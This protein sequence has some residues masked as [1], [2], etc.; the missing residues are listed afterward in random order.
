MYCSNGI[1]THYEH[2]F[3]TLNIYSIRPLYFNFLS[4]CDCPIT[5]SF[6]LVL[7]QREKGFV[8]ATT[9]RCGV[10]LDNL[11]GRMKVQETKFKEISE[12]KKVM[13]RANPGNL[14]H[15]NSSDPDLATKRPVK[16]RT[17]LYHLIGLQT[18]YL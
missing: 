10:G 17:N 12:S 18:K 11:W 5:E 1:L 9:T 2:L 3:R 15:G 8:G 14:G 4:A 13:V 16:H 6:F 7:Y